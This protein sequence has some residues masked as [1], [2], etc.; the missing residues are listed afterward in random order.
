MIAVFNWVKYAICRGAQLC[1]PT[2]VTH[3]IENCYET[4]G[5]KPAQ[6]GFACVGAN[7]IRLTAIRPK[8]K[9]P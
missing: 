2:N 3:A 9:T 6:A 7:S 8:N 5:L 4:N 1:A